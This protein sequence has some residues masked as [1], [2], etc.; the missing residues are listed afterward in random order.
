MS[1]YFVDVAAGRDLVVD[2]KDTVLPDFQASQRLAV[3]ALYDFAGEYGVEC[4]DRI[5][6]TVVRDEA[7]ET[8]YR[9]CVTLTEQTASGFY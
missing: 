4:D 9:A 7:G 5:F 6:T 1:R 8:A 3:R 2:E